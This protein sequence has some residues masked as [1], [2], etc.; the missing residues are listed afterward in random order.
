MF[1]GS[2]IGP[3]LASP[4]LNGRFWGEHNPFLRNEMGFFAASRSI[5][6]QILHHGIVLASVCLVLVGWSLPGI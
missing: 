5:L 4:S 2:T 3:F 1:H 6:A